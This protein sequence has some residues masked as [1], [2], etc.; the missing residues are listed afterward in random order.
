[1]LSLCSDLFV[2]LCKCWQVRAVFCASPSC[3]VFLFHGY[4]YLGI[5]CT[6]VGGRR[7]EWSESGS[8]DYTVTVISRGILLAAPRGPATVRL[9]ENGSHSLLFSPALV[10]HWDGELPWFSK[11]FHWQSLHLWSF[12]PRAAEVWKNI[13]HSGKRGFIYLQPMLGLP[14]LQTQD[15]LG[16]GK[17]VLSKSRKQKAAFF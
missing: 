13:F 8:W 3:W 9:W 12:W 7:W 2:W 16:R 15:S 17:S 6:W 14:H 5:Q 10:F 11:T 1:M 4:S